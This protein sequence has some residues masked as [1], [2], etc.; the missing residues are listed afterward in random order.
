MMIKKEN[1]KKIKLEK[2]RNGQGIMFL[3]AYLSNNEL[4]NSMTGFNMMELQE[5]GE[6]GYHQHK[7]DEEIYF[8]ISGKGIVK[9]NGVEME[10]GE[11]DLIYTKDEEWHGLKNIGNE[12][13]KFIAFIVKK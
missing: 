2:P 7:G 11:G 5:C 13:L 9:D 1:I 4:Q 10:V 3:N 6:I 8:I 12:A